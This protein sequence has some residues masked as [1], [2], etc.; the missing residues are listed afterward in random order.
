[1]TKPPG[2]WRDTC[3]EPATHTPLNGDISTEIAVIGGGFTGL[4]TALHLAQAGSG[5]HVLEAGEIGTGASGRNVGL[6]N[7]G[8]WLPPAAIRAK[9]GADI[10]DTLVSLLGDAPRTVFSLIEKHQIQCEATQSGTIHVSS[11]ARGTTDL[12]DRAAMWQQLGAPVRLLD[13]Q[14]TAQRTGTAHFTAGLFDA[15][16]GTVQP[17]GYAR[18]LARIATAAGATISTQSGVTEITRDSDNWRLETATG[19]LT[20]RRVV[21]AT[22]TY[23]GALWP[24]FQKYQSRINYFQ[25]A[26]EPLGERAAHILP[27]GEGIWD[28]GTIMVSLR[29][30]QA[31]RI[32]LGSMGRIVETA[33]LSQRWADKTLARLLPDIGPVKWDSA[34]HGSI[35]ITPD[36]LPRIVQLADGIYA[37]FGYN[38]RGIAPGTAFGKAMAGMLTGTGSLPLPLSQ[39]TPLRA[40]RLYA[41]A[42]DLSLLAHKALRTVA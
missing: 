35:G 24:D 42:L 31:G 25:L 10:G 37:P 7:A 17:L 5:V 41:K 33:R 19:T 18:G 21:M 8:L 9:L 39:P 12:R 28:C 4:S 23:T 2:L 6:V 16:A 32:I 20:A 1:M 3:A 26:S 13:A 27:G 38:G 36:K 30:D 15:R 14:E 40:P 29:R 11:T 22:N 34:W